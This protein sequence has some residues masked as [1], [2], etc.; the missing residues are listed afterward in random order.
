MNM[1]KLFRIV[2]LI[3]MLSMPVTTFATV[4]NLPNYATFLGSGSTGPYSFNM[5]F[6]ANSQ[7]G[8]TTTDLTGNITTL[9]QNIDYTISV[10]AKNSVGEYAGGSVTLT[11]ALP[12]GYTLTITRTL[13]LSQ[14]TQLPNQGPFYAPTIEAGFDYLTM[15][16]QQLQRNID[17]GSIQGPQGPTGPQGEPGIQGNVGVQGPTGAQGPQGP[18][19]GTFGQN[20]QYI[21][22]QTL[23]AAVTSIG[24]TVTTL[25]V[26]TL[27]TVSAS[28]IV[29]STLTLWVIN[30]AIITINTG[31]SLT[32]NGAVIIP[33]CQVFNIVGTGSVIFGSS[34][35]IKSI[36][37]GN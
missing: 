8:V 3:L 4:A 20:Y 21:G 7:I 14:S 15:I 32:I 18:A 25:L 26:D 28:F 6:F 11:S 30:P 2:L 29:P 10:P 31:Q 9:T 13:P 34:V 24:S 19:G 23:L 17:E 33:D 37:W 12:T 1:K 16:T 35:N 22:N 5:T 36:W 27:Q